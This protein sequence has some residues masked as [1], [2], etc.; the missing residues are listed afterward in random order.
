MHDYGVYSMQINIL[1]DEDEALKGRNISTK[2]E[3]LGYR[4][5]YLFT[6]LKGRNIIGR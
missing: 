2:G 3:A 5:L 4:M 6:A 1:I